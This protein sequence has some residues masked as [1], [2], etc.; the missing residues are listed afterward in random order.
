MQS[1]KATK[2]ISNYLDTRCIDI[3]Y[4]QIA[5]I[6]PV[7]VIIVIP[8]YDESIDTLK[9]SMDSV[10]LSKDGHIKFKLF[11]LINY[12]DSDTDQLKKLSHNIYTS[13][14]RDYEG[15]ESVEIG[16]V[17]MKG[18]IAG[19]GY[20]RKIL[21]DAAVRFYSDIG[22]NG[23]IVNLDADTLVEQNYVSAIY[24]HFENH[25]GHEAVSICYAHDDI[26]SNNA[27]LNYELHLRYFIN[28]QR[29]IR[30]PYA[31]QTIG[32][33][34]AVKSHSYAKEGG[35][36]LRQAG[37]DFYF[38]HKFSRNLSLADMATTVVAPSGRSSHRVPFGTGKAV[39]LFR[40]NI[41]TEI[42]TYNPKSFVVLAEMLQA[43]E[44]HL[45]SSVSITL[46]KLQFFT[47][48]LDID[49]H[50]DRILQSSRD[51]IKRVKNFYAWFDAFQLMKYLHYMRADYPD[52]AIT[53][54]LDFLFATK[55][56]S[57]SPSLK[58]DLVLLRKID[59]ATDY[60]TQWRAGLISRL[61]STN[62]S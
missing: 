18:K 45:S 10:Q 21:M 30:L 20:A 39:S 60:H 23:I 9:R 7:E 27:I 38:L 58:E 46:P 37:E 15:E 4:S 61:S 25:P 51:P 16:I 42:M 62:A 48:Q 8:A 26:D 59:L 29:H 17:E 3:F 35:M 5:S 12:K 19:V 41:T 1:S 32:S 49:H 52:I 6:N 33:A 56:I 2:Y 13:L 14:S 50:L 40:Q 44:G 57:R 47:D 34:M 43:V 53:E 28:M 31:Y 22:R 55:G 54:G 36:S 11:L 24:E